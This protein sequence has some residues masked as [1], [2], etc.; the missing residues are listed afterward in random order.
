MP[1][2]ET[3]SQAPFPTTGLLPCRVMLFTLM[4]VS[5]SAILAVSTGSSRVITTVSNSTG[6]KPLVTVHLKVFNPTLR[7]TTPVLGLV[8][9]A[10]DAEPEST[11]HRPMPDRTGAALRLSELE[12]IVPGSPAYTLPVRLANTMLIVDVLE[13]QPPFVTDHC[14][15]VFPAPIELTRLLSSVGVFIDAMPERTDQVPTP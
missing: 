2:P 13:V 4:I 8:E 15:M 12:Q 3:S 7:F 5:F 6:Q 10:M 11:V 9:S 14:R 1:K